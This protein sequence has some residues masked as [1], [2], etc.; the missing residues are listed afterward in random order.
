[1]PSHVIDFLPEKGLCSFEQIV[2]PTL[3]EK[4]DLMCEVVDHDFYDIGE[5][6]E[7]ARTRAALEGSA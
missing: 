7:L 6:D 4:G 1:M 2:F 3:A 5:P